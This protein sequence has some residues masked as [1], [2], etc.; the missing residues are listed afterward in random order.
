MTHATNAPWEPPFLRARLA[1]APFAVGVDAQ[2]PSLVCSH[3][4]TLV[5]GGLGRLAWI[6]R[7]SDGVVLRW[8]E[9]DAYAVHAVLF[10]P[11]DTRLYAT[12]DRGVVAWRVSDGQRVF[13][14]AGVFLRAYGALSPDGAWLLVEAVN[15][16]LV[17]DA[18][19]GKVLRSN[20]PPAATGSYDRVAPTFTADGRFAVTS[21]HWLRRWDLAAQTSAELVGPGPFTHAAA[22]G[23]GA[24]MVVAGPAL[25]LD[26]YDVADGRRV[27]SGVAP[28]IVRGL[29]VSGDTL[30][31]YA[32]S[33]GHMG[34]WRLTPYAVDTLAPIEGGAITKVYLF[35]ALAVRGDTLWA[36]SNGSLRSAAL[37]EGRDLTKAFA[38]RGDCHEL[39]FDRDAAHLSASFG[40]P[41]ANNAAM[42]WS[43]ATGACV[44]VDTASSKPQR[45]TPD[46]RQLI[47]PALPGDTARRIAL[48]EARA[49]EAFDP[50]SSYDTAFA[51]GPDGRAVAID[52][53]NSK[54]VADTLRVLPDGPLYALPRKH[55]LGYMPV[56]SVDDEI[57]IAHNFKALGA[58]DLRAAT[59][60]EPL[61]VPGF[62]AVAVIGDRAWVVGKSAQ[63]WDVRARTKLRTVKL[64]LTN[65]GFPV[66]AAVS[67]D[68][69]LLA[70][71]CLVGHVVLLELDGAERSLTFRAGRTG[72]IRACAFSDD[73]A[74]L[75]TGGAEP[76]VRV[77]DVRA[78]LATAPAAAKKSK[79]AKK[80]G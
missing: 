18:Q 78:A 56:W 68:G 51:P 59:W 72:M 48:D 30:W 31:V 58:F 14:I 1:G 70:I 19:R 23:D 69:T 32:D 8:L 16:Q 37:S 3:D 33:P 79:G 4:G 25:A 63:L 35:T 27:A 62:R 5:A 10:S 66:S 45:L 29:F 47:T 73:G 46:G 17:I 80:K 12:S 60:L 15:A 44:V 54:A 34:E 76:Y 77:W 55:A 39:R 52:A 57:V 21:D 65:E 67:R 49:V 13:H 50:A 11:D 41:G 53:R 36:V 61:A 64:A 2:T 71:G 75:A 20:A 28:G 40:A 6:A 22:V 42:R 24:H 9:T 26:R 38:A 7:A 43:I 74:L